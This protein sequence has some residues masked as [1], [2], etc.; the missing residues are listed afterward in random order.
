MADPK[1][2][3]ADNM[4]EQA[5]EPRL[6]NVQR[7]RDDTDQDQGA[8]D[9]ENAANGENNEAKDGE[10]NGEGDVIGEDEFGPYYRDPNNPYHGILALTEIGI[11]DSREMIHTA[12]GLGR[13]LHQCSCK[14]IFFG[15]MATLMFFAVLTIT[16]MRLAIFDLFGSADVTVEIAEIMNLCFVLYFVYSAVFFERPYEIAAAVFAVGFTWLLITINYAMSTQGFYKM[17]RIMAASAT[18]PFICVVGCTIIRSYLITNS[19]VFRICGSNMMMQERCRALFQYLA[20]IKIDFQVQMTLAILVMKD[21][22]NLGVLEWI[23]LILIAGLAIASAAL[24]YLMVRYEHH[25]MTL[26]FCGLWFVMPAVCIYLIIKGAIFV[27]AEGHTEEQVGLCAVIFV[28]VI[29]CLIVRVEVMYY[30]LKVFLNYGFGLR[31][32][33]FEGYIDEE[34]RERRDPEDFWPWRGFDYRYYQNPV[35]VYRPRPIP[36]PIN[37]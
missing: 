1:L 33:A 12:L 36:R 2:P 25:K 10:E 37:T 31:Q 26:A 6:E 3:L 20:L 23:F 9:E 27:Q 34:N 11:R 18:G 17:I 15:V 22:L 8:A 21:G 14:D 13:Y 29:I 16:V 4:E 19:V 35:P 32:K 7:N 30:V 5:V 24:G 28:G